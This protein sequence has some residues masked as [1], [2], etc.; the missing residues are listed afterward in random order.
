MAFRLLLLSFFTLTAMLAQ[1]QT[2]THEVM[3]FNSV[4]E[5][6]KP[7]LVKIE[8]ER[9]TD[10]KDVDAFKHEFLSSFVS[11]YIKNFNQTRT[12]ERLH[13]S[14]VVVRKDGYII[15]S[16]KLFEP[17]D[18]IY[19]T[20]STN[21][22]LEAKIINK[23]NTRAL[24]LLKI[25]KN[26]LSP[27]PLLKDNALKIGDIVLSVNYNQNLLSS[28]G[29]VSAD[30]KEKSEYIKA[31]ITTS[32]ENLSAILINTN[33]EF[34]GFFN[35]SIYTVAENY[36]SFLK[37][38]VLY[39]L[40]EQ[41]IHNKMPQSIQ[42]DLSFDIKATTLTSIIRANYKLPSNMSGVLVENVKDDSSAFKAGIKVNDIIV[43]IESENIDSKE[44]F[45]NALIKYFDKEKRIFLLRNGYPM[46]KILP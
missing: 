4:I 20:L 2:N 32:N 43:Q 16:N 38:K 42:E 30:I 40:I 9:K 19:I 44:D 28:L 29:M 7:S 22:R 8:I 25:D 10:I 13:T 1:T 27:L 21:E 17:H 46:V 15:T 41:M 6:I 37:A 36:S 45:Y 14:G 3:S 12:I 33:A 23:D 35:N 39:E 34:V 24:L 11:G 18:K 5:R 26:D 31:S